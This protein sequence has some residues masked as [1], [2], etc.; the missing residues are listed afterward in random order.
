MKK[1]SWILPLIAAFAVTSCASY[2]A[3]HDMRAMHKQCMQ[4]GKKGE[5]MCAD[6]HDKE[7]NDCCCMDKESH[8]DMNMKGKSCMVDK[9]KDMGK[10]SD[11]S[12]P[13]LMK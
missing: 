2:H 4:E 10:S 8:G 9:K 3:R 7:M 5:M 13:M 11:A 6:K 1:Y 12:Q